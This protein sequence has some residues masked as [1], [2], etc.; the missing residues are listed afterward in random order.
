MDDVVDDLLRISERCARAA[1]VFQEEPVDSI[2]R[3]RVGHVTREFS[4]T[5]GLGNCRFLQGRPD[6]A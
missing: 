6:E 2:H 3:G 1:R 4:E 5:L